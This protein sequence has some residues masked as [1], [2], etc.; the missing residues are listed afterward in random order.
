MNILDIY[1]KYVLVLTQ[2]E[3]KLFETWAPVALEVLQNG[4]R[5]KV[6][7]EL[8]EEMMY[9]YRNNTKPQK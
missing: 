4:P 2:K 7:G 8:I 3:P 9:E 1:R 6:T 5:L